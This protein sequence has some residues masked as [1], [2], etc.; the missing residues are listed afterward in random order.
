MVA[1][2]FDPEVGSLLKETI[3]A[4][5]DAYSDAIADQ[6]LGRDA[7]EQWRRVQVY[8]ARS[9]VIAGLIG[10]ASIVEESGS[11][12]LVFES[13]KVTFARTDDDLTLFGRGPF[14]E[15][16]NAFRDRVPMLRSN[17][18]AL[19]ADA[20][21]ASEFAVRSEMESALPYL[22]SHSSALGLARER[23]FWASDVDLGA[24]INLKEIVADVVRGTADDADIETLS[25]VID[26]SQ[27][28]GA[29]NL[30]RS[31]IETVIRTNVS[32]AHNDGRA[33]ALSNSAVAS[34]IPLVM[35]IEIQDSRTRGNPIGLY[36]RGGPHYQMDGYVGT[37]EDFRRQGIIP[38]NGYN[39]RGGI[40]GVPM[41]EAMRLGLLTEQGAPDVKAIAAYNGQRQRFIDLVE[42]PDEGFRTAA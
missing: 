42:Y 20:S 37:I 38:P 36:P 17:V 30:T 22:E 39:C 32:S 16:I 10:M 15:A 25:E 7:S 1:L 29:W 13:E 26:R 21:L 35:L 2:A 4:A 41:A 5:S 28:A 40:R 27:V 23:A 8:I 3:D 19:I 12:G 33:S 14:L 24:I 31:R 34:A 18:D 6:F 9:Y 11:E